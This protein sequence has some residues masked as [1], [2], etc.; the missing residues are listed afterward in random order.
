MDFQRGRL[1][2]A[3]FDA[4]SVYSWAI[5]VSALAYTS[6]PDPAPFAGRIWFRQILCR[7]VQQLPAIHC[8]IWAEYLA[9]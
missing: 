6:A 8:R 7:D 1:I 9:D 3:A 5:R 4:K 2:N